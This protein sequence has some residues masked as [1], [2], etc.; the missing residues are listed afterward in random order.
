MKSVFDWS[1]SLL[2][3][4]FLIVNCLK[5]HRKLSKPITS[6]LIYQCEMLGL[7][8]IWRPSVGSYVDIFIFCCNAL[9]HNNVLV[10]KS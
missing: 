5:T 1:F 4:V 10:I 6:S 9:T 3:V 7:A 2:M 8:F